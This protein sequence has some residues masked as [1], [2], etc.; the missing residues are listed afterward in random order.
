MP[1]RTNEFQELVARIHRAFAPM[2]AKVTESIMMG[3]PGLEGK[4]E[5]DVLIELQSGL[6]KLMVAV[7]AKHESRKMDLVKFES[8]VGKYMG[9]GCVKVNKVVVVSHLGFYRNVHRRARLLNIELITLDEAFDTDWSK[10]APKRVQF[11]MK[12][13]ICSVQFE[14][15]V[16]ALKKDL[17]DTAR[18]ICQH[19]ADHGSVRHYAQHIVNSHILP[20]SPGLLQRLWEEATHH[21]RGAVATV[22]W[23]LNSH[24]V[25][26]D[27]VDHPVSEMEIRL[28][29][30]NAQGIADC[31]ELELESTE[32]GKRTIQRACV[33]VGGKE[34]EVLFPEGH[35]SK[36][37]ML[38]IGDTEYFSSRKS[39]K[40][41]QRTNAARKGR[42]PKG[43]HRD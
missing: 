31:T 23:P 27:D 43:T 25:R 32:N 42:K 24:C 14:P 1:Q 29:A 18:I 21:E 35:Q 10:F 26:L 9:D 40:K 20:K 28:H 19:G 16:N 38:T 22:S 17:L 5:I 41:P 8:I 13:H 30:I 6:Y 7:E 15:R 4:R 12:P 39:A 37:I 11:K 2:G 33:S 3:V 34:L 36:K